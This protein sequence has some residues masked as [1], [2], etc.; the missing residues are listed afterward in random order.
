M[1]KDLLFFRSSLIPLQ[2]VEELDMPIWEDLREVTVINVDVDG[3][4]LEAL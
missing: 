3:N 1:F 4:T 2:L